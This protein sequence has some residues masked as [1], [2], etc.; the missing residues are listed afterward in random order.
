[1]G[2][3]ADMETFRTQRRVPFTPRQMFDLVADV[4]SYPE[5]LPLCEGMRVRSR[6]QLLA[7]AGGGE[8][9][10]VLVADM[11]MGYRAIRETISSRVTLEPQ[12]PRVGVRYLSGPFSRMTNEWRFE[13]VPEGC[14]VQFYIAYEVRN[15]LLRYLVS[16]LFDKAFKRF[17]SAFEARAHQVYRRGNPPIGSPAAAQQN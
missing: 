11:T 15:P 17:A 10:E 2:A 14:I 6:Q 4:E 8:P 3:D 13:P 1:M 5:F 7:D 16:Q 12:I 9:S